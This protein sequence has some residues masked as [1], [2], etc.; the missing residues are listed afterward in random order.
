MST[1]DSDEEEDAEDVFPLKE[2]VERSWV[3]C[4]KKNALDFLKLK[5]KILFREMLEFNQIWETCSYAYAAQCCDRWPAVKEVRLDWNPQMFSQLAAKVV[6][7]VAEGIAEAVK[8]AVRL[9]DGRMVGLSKQSK[10]SWQEEFW[11][12]EE[13]MGRDSQVKSRLVVTRTWLYVEAP[14]NLKA[15]K[16]A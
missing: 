12:A 1:E 5:K 13:G 2:A 15:G 11:T 14:R 9:G 16:H 3:S 10:S 4:L 7:G 8:K 6:K